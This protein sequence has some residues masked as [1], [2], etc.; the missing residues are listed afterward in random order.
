MIGCEYLICL[1]PMVSALKFIVVE[2]MYPAYK[3]ININH[4]A[5]KSFLLTLCYFVH[6]P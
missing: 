5:K 6:M 1:W 4:I 2:Q 3:Q